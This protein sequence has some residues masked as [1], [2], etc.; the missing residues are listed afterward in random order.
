M[1]EILCIVGLIKPDLFAIKL[2]ESEWFGVAQLIICIALIWLVLFLALDIRDIIKASTK[3]N[4]G[5]P[6]KNLFVIFVIGYVMF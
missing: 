3:F 1:L 5:F 2:G 6:L 4:E